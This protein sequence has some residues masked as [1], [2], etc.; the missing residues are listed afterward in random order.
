[1]STGDDRRS[2]DAL[3]GR[4]GD[5]DDVRRL[6]QAAGSRT[7]LPEA[8]RQRI[9]TATAAVFD[10]LPAIPAP[11]SG[12][13]GRF[14]RYALVAG[15][16]LAFGLAALIYRQTS[17]PPTR[18]G[19]ELAEVIFAAGSTMIAGRSPTSGGRVTMDTTLRTGEDGRAHLRLASGV[20]LRV[21]G[22]TELVLV[23]TQSLRLSYG[24]IYVDT[25]QQGSIRVL[26]GLG[27]VVDVGTQ[28]AIEMNGRRL[29]VLVR[30]G[31]VR[32]LQAS[33]Q[34]VA[35][36]E[37]GSGEAL[38]F[39]DRGLIERRRMPST[40]AYWRWI[41]SARA[42]YPLEG[43]TLHDYLSWSARECG[44]ALSYSGQASEHVARSAKLHGDLTDAVCIAAIDE[45]LM[46]S[47]LQRVS[48]AD[49]YRLVIDFDDAD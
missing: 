24:R 18:L 33:T 37:E 28:F 20:E 27:E 31:A 17:S 32:V 35:R 8:A 45:I 30:D 12:S 19:H 29:D 11:L 2:P 46:T 9:Y 7:E 48:P 16:I 3:P 1:M 22:K 26:T 10:D 42:D 25:A 39:D 14:R 4:E 5:D 36:A 38:R 40:H 15:W 23:D 49:G 13:T 44:L 34:Q 41:D 43:G 21:D 6:L 47:R